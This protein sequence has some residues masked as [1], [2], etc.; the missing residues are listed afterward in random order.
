MYK[1]ILYIEDE[2]AIAEIYAELLRPHGYEV[3]LAYDGRSGLE[4]AQN[5][6]YDVIL[7]DLMLPYM[8]GL[9][10]LEA[11]KDKTKSPNFSDQTDIFILTNFDVDD[12]TRQ[13]ILTKAQGYLIKVE[14]TPKK[15]AEILEERGNAKAA[16]ATV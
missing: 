14:V 15:L 8:S 12:I 9:E 10:I 16:V 7:L 1:T 2:R 5:K 3:D 13:Q 4:M 11:L 6:P